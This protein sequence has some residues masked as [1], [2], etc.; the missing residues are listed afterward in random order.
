MAAQSMMVEAYTEYYKAIM[1]ADNSV[2]GGGYYTV[3]KGNGTGWNGTGIMTDE[4]RKAG[5]TWNDFD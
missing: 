5:V 1:E 2:S 3:Y 4:M